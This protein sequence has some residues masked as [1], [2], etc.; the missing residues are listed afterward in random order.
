LYLLLGITSSPL[1]SE[2]G[3][4]FVK[5]LPMAADGASNG[6]RVT[7]LTYPKKHAKVVDN[8]L[9]YPVLA[10]RLMGRGKKFEGSTKDYEIKVSKTNQMQWFSGTPTLNMQNSS[11][12][13]TLSYAHTAGTIPVVVSLL[14][15]MANSGSQQVINLKSFKMD[16]AW[17]EMA[18]SLGSVIYGLGA[19]DQPN[20]IGRLA[21][22][23]TSADQIGGQSRAT[24]AVL[25][26]TK[27]ASG[28]SVSLA[29]MA[30][31]YDAVSAAG[32][33]TEEPTIGV[34]TKTVWSLIE[35]LLAPAVRAEY[36]SVG[37]NALAV[38][39][40]AVEPS[41]AALK[42]AA[43]FNAITFRGMP[44]IKDDLATAQTLFFLNERYIDW[45]G[46][47]EVPAGFDE[48]SYVSLGKR[49][50]TMEGV[51][52]APSENHGIFAQEFSMVPSQPASFA[53]YYIIGQLVTSQ[54]RR[55]GQLTGIT[56]V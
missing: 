33:G 45:L 46:R 24:Y 5:E 26:G 38:R 49:D 30:T 17:S 19:G 28:G 39:G 12:T 43:G 7:G 11:T 36:Q 2:S 13:I 9:N 20:G 10:S 18:E 53:R 47:T 8:V 29:K 56:S 50:G 51:A 37:Y 34:T 23:G 31:L 3:D 40:D 22:D 55:H 15:A 35:Q 54:P 41:K 16:E 42:G 44:I 14:E 25:K 1:F 6:Q 48:L 4:F 21:D 52:A 32:A 27:T